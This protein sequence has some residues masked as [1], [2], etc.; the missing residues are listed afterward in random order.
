MRLELFCLIGVVLLALLAG[1][2]APGPAESPAAGPGDR[3]PRPP[4]PRPASTVQTPPESWLALQPARPLGPPLAEIHEVCRLDPDQLAR[5]RDRMELARHERTAWQQALWERLEQARRA[6]GDPLPPEKSRRIEQ[7]IRR[8]R[9]RCEQLGREEIRDILA[10]L[11]AAQR[12]AWQV[13][14]LGQALRAECDGLAL[15]GQQRRSVEAICRRK[16]QALPGD[17][18]Q[19]SCEQVSEAMEAVYLD[20][21]DRAQRMRY[22]ALVARRTRQWRLAR[23]AAEDPD[24]PELDE[25]PD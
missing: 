11:T 19:P 3:Q 23:A 5:A 1:Q 18:P 10:L 7:T 22:A 8:L 16:G 24:R 14:R 9:A 25:P 21:L 15:T 20:V 4:A 6:A 13:H 12:R 2:S 17:Q